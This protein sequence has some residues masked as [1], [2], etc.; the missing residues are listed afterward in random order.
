MI[1]PFPIFPAFKFRFVLP[2]AEKNFFEQED[3][4]GREGPNR[5]EQA[6]REVREGPARS[7]RASR[8]SCSKMIGPFPIFPAFLFQTI[9]L[10]PIFAASGS[11][12][13]DVPAPPRSSC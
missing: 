5:I 12:L 11:S 6:E 9:G 13:L 8:P 2:R 3:R 1:G 4:E 10:C 7:S